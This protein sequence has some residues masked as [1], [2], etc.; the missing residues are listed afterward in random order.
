MRVLLADDENM[1]LGALSALLSLEDDIEVVAQAEDGT[2]AFDLACI[3][4]PDVCVLD[5]HMPGKD[6]ITVTRDLQRAVPGTRC[7]VLTSHAAPGYLKQ[8]LQAGARGFVPKTTSAQQL[9]G[10]IRE[11]HL[12]AQYVDPGMAA[13]ALSSGDSPLTRR[14]ADILGLAA[15]GAPICE[16][17]QRAALRPG[18]VRNYL[19]DIMGKLNVANRH[20]AVHV[21]RRFGWI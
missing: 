9:A 6:G 18:T 17:A 13:D 3:H 4:S 19:S 8:A 15:D 7:M 21:A 10:I 5:L 1:I 12:G 14:E 11:V 2:K 16:I 20:E